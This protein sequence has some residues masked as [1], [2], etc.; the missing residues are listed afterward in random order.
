MMKKWLFLS[1]L[2][3]IYAAMTFAAAVAQE[4]TTA[5]MPTFGDLRRGW[6]DITPPGAICARGT[7]YE[8]YA[9][10]GDPQKL[11][12]YFQG[13]G[14]CWN[15]FTC[16]T[17]RGTFD[18]SVEDGELRQYVGMFAQR[19]ELNPVRDYSIIV[20]T[21][22]TGDFH[23]GDVTLTYGTSPN[24]F[25]IQ[26]RGFANASLVLDW[27]YQNFPV[28]DNLLIAGSSAGSIGAM[29]NA[30]RILE[31]YTAA[32][33]DI[34]AVVLGDGGVGVTIPVLDSVDIW[35]SAANVTWLPDFTPTSDANFV[36]QIIEATALAYPNVRFAEYTSN[37][38]L[39]QILFYQLMGGRGSADEWQTAVRGELSE[40]GA[41][42]NFN[43]YIVEGKSHTILPLPLFYDAEQDGVTFLEWFGSLIDG[44]TVTNVGQ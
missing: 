15:E 44:E 36:N 24:T 13:G 32:N 7:P 31:H 20:V 2:L 26:H 37:E 40:L 4:T 5:P 42:P 38:D 10:P 11:I 39:V 3:L 19:N 30:G 18:D 28:L 35:G 1:L 34:D 17:G 29:Y 27:A 25:E 43:W 23:S 14:G 41:L 8:F 6:N 9:R 12:I 22:C 33:P 21:Y 16:G